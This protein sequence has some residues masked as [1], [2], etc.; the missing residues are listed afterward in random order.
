MKKEIFEKIGMD[1]T[2]FVSDSEMD[3]LKEGKIAIPY[4]EDSKQRLHRIPLSALKLIGT[5]QLFTD[6]IL[7]HHMIVNCFK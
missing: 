4:S 2:F 1:E 3:T 5:S 6:R 7:Y